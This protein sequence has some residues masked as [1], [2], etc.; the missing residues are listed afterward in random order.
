MNINFDI[1]IHPIKWL[2]Y[3]LPYEKRNACSIIVSSYDIRMN[4]LDKLNSK[5]IFSFADISEYKNPLSFNK[6][7]ARK[8]HQY[9]DS[10]PSD[11]EV[12]FV[13]CDSGESRS[14]AITAAILRYLGRDEMKIW[15]NPHY[16]PNPLV[17]KL[18]CREF[19]FHLLNDDIEEKIKINQ[20]A[21]YQAISNARKQN[22]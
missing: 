10:L 2:Y 22:P 17:Y 14:S 16:H 6:D 3:N 12:L 9:V 4:K 21:L 11:T 5:I 18:L 15:Q 13:C 8:I 1:E 19:G 7:H 20:K